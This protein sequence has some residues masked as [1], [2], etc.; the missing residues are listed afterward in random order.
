MIVCMLEIWKIEVALNEKNL[1]FFFV[2]ETLSVKG[3]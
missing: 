3:F 1:S 2:L